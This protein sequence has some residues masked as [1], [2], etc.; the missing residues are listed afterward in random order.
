MT[1]TPEKLLKNNIELV[2]LPDIVFQLNNMVNDPLCNAAEIGELIAKDSVLT[3]R[4]LKIVNS[5][6][7]GFPSSIDSIPMAITVLGVRQ[8]RDLV[9]TS[10]VIKKYSK[11]P[12]SILDADTF[13][14]H[15]IA[16][17]LCAQI[18]ARQVKLSHSDR[19][20]TCGMLHDIGLLILALTS[21]DETRQVLE[22]ARD[23]N[24]PSQEFQNDVFGFTQADVGAALIRKWHLPESLIE[25]VLL[26]QTNKAATRFPM[27]T[28][29][30]KVAN[31]IANNNK[32]TAIIGDNQIIHP[33]T[34]ELLGLTENALNDIQEELQDSLQSTLN[35]IYVE[36]AA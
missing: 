10:C 15:S 7:Y 12:S 35:I 25:P 1:L 17:A 14:H 3:I 6:F 29:I 31:V 16:T 21:P 2:S 33:G 20:F 27:E 34:L 9:F 13:W 28:A 8:L 22:L 24:K 26:Q 32:Q 19:L 23:T 4:L 11:I 30:L 5:P 18:I 36:Q